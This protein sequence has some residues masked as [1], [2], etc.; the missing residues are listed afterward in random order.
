MLYA[1][2]KIQS[3]KLKGNES[4]EG[5]SLEKE[6]RLAQTQGIKP[7]RNITEIFYTQKKD[8][9]LASCDI[10]TDRFE[11]GQNAMDKVNRTFHEKIQEQI[12]KQIEQKTETKEAE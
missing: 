12:K 1:R 2:K 8:G 6:L 10:R 3:N 9:V 5:V 7:D 4:F 11:I